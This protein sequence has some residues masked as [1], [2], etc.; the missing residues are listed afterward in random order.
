MTAKLYT[1]T[2]MASDG[3]RSRAQLLYDGVLTNTTKMK[4]GE[5]SDIPYRNAC[6]RQGLE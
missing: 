1:G 5:R 6:S 4:V 3:K 2:L